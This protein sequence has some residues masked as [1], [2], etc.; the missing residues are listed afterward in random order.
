MKLKEKQVH[1]LFRIG[2]S[3]KGIDGFLEFVCG[4][5]LLIAGHSFIRKLVARLAH[6]ELV[7]DP[8]DFVATHLVRFANHFSIGTQH[9]AAIYLLLHGLTKL[10]LVAGLLR[11]KLWAYPTALAVL[12]FLLCYQAYRF[13]HNHSIA[14]LVFS[15]VDVIIIFLIWREYGF[16]KAHHARGR[17][18]GIK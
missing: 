4:L 17:V 10:G 12:G 5:A 3:V 2:I 8:H 9:F 7:E 14:L 11:G 15:V 13:I 6:G 1:F 16:R 18:E